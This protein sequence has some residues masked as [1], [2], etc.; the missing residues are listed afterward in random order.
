MVHPSF[1]NTKTIRIDCFE[2]VPQNNNYQS[3]EQS[4]D[5]FNKLLDYDKFK[6]LKR[7]IPKIDLTNE[8]S[9][10]EAAIEGNIEE[11]AIEKQE[12]S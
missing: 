6:D 7:D 1:A 10:E 4:V 11:E 9:N 12:Q 8:Q 5:Y 2:K 3:L